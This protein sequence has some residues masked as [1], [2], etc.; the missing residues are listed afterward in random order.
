M[1]KSVFFLVMVLSSSYALAVEPTVEVKIDL[2][3][4]K[5]LQL[6][7]DIKVTLPYG[8]QST[9][10]QD[11]SQVVTTANEQ[12]Q[13]SRTETMRELQIRG[14]TVVNAECSKVHAFTQG[15]WYGISHLSISFY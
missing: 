6:V 14:Y 3:Q 8:G 4:T 11:K 5:V 7:K 13:T 2:S 10:E 1:L 9:Y 12:C 15:L